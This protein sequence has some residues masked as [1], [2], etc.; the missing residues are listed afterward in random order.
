MTSNTLQ[1]EKE[2]F[3]F[4]SYIDRHKFSIMLLLSG[5]I[6]VG[7]GVLYV[8]NDPNPDGAKVEVLDS[9]TEGVGGA[10]GIVVEVVGA[11]EKPGVYEFVI[12]DRV[13]DALIAAGGVSVDADREWM[14]KVLNRA[15]K[16]VDGQKIYIPKIGDEVA[17]AENNMYANTGVADVGKELININTASQKQLESLWGIGPVYAQNIIEQ[18]PYSSVEELLSKGVIKSNVYEKNKEKMTIY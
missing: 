1:N 12:G 17:G 16:L 5:V 13:N 10:N 4:E 7:F 18:R 2:G 11:V 6:L 3:D 15:S 8:K 9:T 14:E